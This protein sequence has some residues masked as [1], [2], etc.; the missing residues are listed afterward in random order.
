MNHA[1]GGTELIAT[2]DDGHAVGDFRQ[3]QSFL[4]GGI[5]AA[6]DKNL[7]ATKEHAIARRAIRNATTAIR[8]LAN[9]TSRSR[10]GTHASDNARGQRI[11]RIVMHRKQR[12]ISIVIDARH[13]APC[14]LRSQTLCMLL[15]TL[16]KLGT[17]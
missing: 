12:C 14:N 17:A 16:A 4:A 15:K 1:I 6:N 2:Q 11:A 10:R 3:E 8:I 9:K 7:L 13:H 5:A